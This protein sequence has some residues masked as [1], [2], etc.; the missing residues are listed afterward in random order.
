[1]ERDIRNMLGPTIKVYREKMG[2]SQ[3]CLA[4]RL[5]REGIN[6]DRT[7]IVKI[8]NQTRKISD[9]EIYAIAKILQIKH[10]NLFKDISK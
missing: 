2:I 1:M 4:E 9:I 7:M 3:G 6:I 8:E 10:K 5:N